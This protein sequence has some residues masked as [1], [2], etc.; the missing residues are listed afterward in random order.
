VNRGEKEQLKFIGTPLEDSRIFLVDENRQPLTTAG[1]GEIVIDC[2]FIAP[3]YWQNTGE[4]S[5]RF[6]FNP[7][8][9][10]LFFTG[11]LGEQDNQHRISIAGRMD[12]QV[13]IDGIRIEPGEIESIMMAHDDIKEAVVVATENENGDKYLCAY[14]VTHTAYS[15]QKSNHKTSIIDKITNHLKKK[16]PG[17]MI[18]KQIVQVEKLPLTASGKIDRRA[19]RNNV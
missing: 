13:K 7:S 14:F 19:L 10:S 8:G 11:D 18:P 1:S 15:H 6:Q 17:F 4:T 2:P 16:L 5:Q 9:R 3:G 12:H